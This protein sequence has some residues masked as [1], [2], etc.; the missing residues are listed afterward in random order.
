MNISV[1]TSHLAYLILW[2]KDHSTVI[3]ICVLYIPDY[4]VHVMVPC[5]VPLE[6]TDILDCM[7]LIHV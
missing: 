2:I 5:S 4:Y 1:S 7:Y 3:P 6:A